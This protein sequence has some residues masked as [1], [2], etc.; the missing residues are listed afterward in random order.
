MLNL[1]RFILNLIWA[2]FITTIVALFLLIIS[3]LPVFVAL[4]LTICTVA[5]ILA[6]PTRS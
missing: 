2:V 5:V 1:L 6:I 3:V 4:L